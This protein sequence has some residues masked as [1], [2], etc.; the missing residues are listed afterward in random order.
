MTHPE[1]ISTDPVGDN[2]PAPVLSDPPA[3]R[4]GPRRCPT[5]GG[6]LVPVKPVVVIDRGDGPVAGRGPVDG[7]AAGLR[8]WGGA[9]NGS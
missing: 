7:P 3:E 2:W 4:P 8:V 6:R 9:G 1:P 5:C